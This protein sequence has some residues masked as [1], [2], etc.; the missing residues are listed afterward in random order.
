V[1]EGSLLQKNLLK[2]LNV[3]VVGQDS[4]MRYAIVYRD[5]D[6]NW[7]AEVP[8]LPGCI[9]QGKTRDEAIANI[10]DAIVLYLQGMNPNELELHQEYIQPE[11]VAI[12]PVVE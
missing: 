10:R 3:W 8:S 4:I 12:E 9:S 2:L 7:I 11:L 5:E 1:L 6:G